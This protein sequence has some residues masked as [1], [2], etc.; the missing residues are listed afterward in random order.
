MLK[1]SFVMSE[2]LVSV[3]MGTY[4]HAPFVAEAIRSV[5]AQDFTDYE[6]LIADDGS[7]DGT[8]SVVAEFS[9]PRLQFRPHPV[10]RGAAVVLNE[11]VTQ[12]RGRYIC[13]LNSDDA[14][15]GQK[16]SEQV[17][18]LQSRPEIGAVFG[19]VLFVDRDGNPI[20]KAS[21]SF[22]TVFDQPDRT[23]GEWLRHFFWKGNCLCHPSVMIRR[24][25]YA[26]VGLYD[27]RL[28]QLPDLDMW[29]RVVKVADIF[30][31]P[32]TMVR[33]RIMPG[34]NTSSDTLTN[35]VRTLNEHFFISLEFFNNVSADLLRQGFGDCLRRPDLP[36]ESSLEIEAALLF[37]RPVVSLEQVY[38]FIGLMK[39]REL[40]NNENT[41][42]LLAADYDFDDRALHRLA[43]EAS[44]L[45]RD[46]VQIST[47]VSQIST[48]ELGRIFGARLIKRAQRLGRLGGLAKL[49]LQKSS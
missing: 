33:F 43:V 49:S 42:A 21:L 6:F 18:I 11:L 25:I 10:N 15:M 32:S 29:I 19:R 41:R 44:V 7:S 16:L 17:A 8:A 2:P 1:G 3:V 40:L 14:W 39:L 47:D 38:K 27:N 24:D 30:V 48:K 28:R 22:G 26:A 4:N 12:A 35:R 45:H 37:L 13:V 5:L 9:D 36:L 46:V 23:R 20:D 31:S 34:E